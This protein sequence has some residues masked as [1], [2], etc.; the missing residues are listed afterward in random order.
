MPPPHIR[1]AETLCAPLQFQA[2]VVRR[3]IEIESR[4]IYR[5]SVLKDILLP[6]LCILA[7]RGVGLWW[8]ALLMNGILAG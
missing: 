1:L 6:T 2:L 4:P 7:E 3:Q 8:L 5:P